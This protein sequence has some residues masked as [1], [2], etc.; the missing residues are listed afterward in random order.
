MVRIDLAS[1]SALRDGEFV[2]F[3]RL[4]PDDLARLTVDDRNTVLSCLGG[5]TFEASFGPTFEATSF[6]PRPRNNVWQYLIEPFRYQGESDGPFDTHNNMVPRS[7]IDEEPDLIDNDREERFAHFGLKCNYERPDPYMYFNR[8]WPLVALAPNRDPVVKF[9][10]DYCKSGTALVSTYNPDFDGEEPD[11]GICLDRLQIDSN[12]KLVPPGLV[13]YKVLIMF[14]DRPTADVKRALKLA[15]GYPDIIRCLRTAENQDFDGALVHPSLLGCTFFWVSRHLADM[16]LALELGGHLELARDLA[17]MDLAERE[18][19]EKLKVARK[20]NRNLEK[21]T[22]ASYQLFGHPDKQFKAS[23]DDFSAPYIKRTSYPTRD[24]WILCLDD[25]RLND[26]RIYREISESAS[27]TSAAAEE[28]SK[29]RETVKLRKPH[30]GRSHGR[31]PDHVATHKNTATAHV[32]T[33][34]G[35]ISVR[36]L[37]ILHSSSVR[38][39]VSD[40]TPL[41]A[42]PRLRDS[43]PVKFLPGNPCPCS[44]NGSIKTPDA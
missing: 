44:F 43:H 27:G 34:N 36:L 11:P 41:A 32:V 2:F 4:S 5:S 7:D 13:L 3:D 21:F 39:S 10:A 33:S 20:Y 8:D 24:A 12:G 28:L 31:P 22:R 6:E 25:I 9:S 37:S 15:A 23:C 1:Q 35:D 18:R 29:L 38:G 42:A 40:V 30:R 19:P 17:V 26:S 16:I 14:P